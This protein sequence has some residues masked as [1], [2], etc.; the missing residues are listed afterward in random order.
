MTA[1]TKNTLKHLNIDHLKA[2]A[3]YTGPCVTIQ[4]P[5]YHPGDGG[6]SRVAHLRQ[7]TQAAADGLRKLDR[8]GEADQVAA[9]LGNLIQSLP[10]ESGGPGMTLFCA[11]HFEAA[12][13]TPGVRAE[14][15]TIGSHFHLVPQLAAA[16][17]PQDF[18][19]L[20]ISRKNLRLFHYRHGHCQELPLPA[21][22]P[23][24]LDAAGAFD[25][26]DH[27]QESRSSGGPS[28]GAMRGVRFGTS[29]DHDS[30]AEYLRHFF[31]QIDK[32][33]KETLKGAP[34]FLAG[35]QEELSL[36]RKAAK[37]AHILNAEFHGNI[38][39]TSIEDIAQHA[40]A[41]ALRDY[42]DASNRA[43]KALP[44]ITQKLTGDPEEVLK[45]A[46]DG[47]VRQIFV[48]EDAHMARANVVGVYVGEDILNAA[49]V[50]GLRT[51][52]E[53]FSIPGNEI[54]GVGPI[55]AVLRF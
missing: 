19:I 33:L 10:V 17:A 31:E 13:E 2:L 37:H 7:L 50:E 28:V 5:S 9:A 41:A 1:T 38:E 43:L 52:A 6:G 48:A 22:V 25:K 53:I 4:L 24:S 12:Y 34:L 26:P 29:S 49:V 11:P 36:Y 27:T 46:Q 30:E 15:V 47:R 45:A 18:H 32:G 35:V 16:Q 3:R 20:G 40:G 44:E 8:P 39:H 54:S 23:A 55:A 14:E 21:S 42:Q 51:G